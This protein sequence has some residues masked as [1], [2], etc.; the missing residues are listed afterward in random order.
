MQNGRRRDGSRRVRSRR[1][2]Q[3]PFDDQRE[4]DP[5]Q[6]KQEQHPVAPRSAV[7]A[8]TATDS[9]GADQVVPSASW[10]ACRPAEPRAARRTEDGYVGQA[11][12]VH[13]IPGF[14]RAGRG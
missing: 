2:G 4:A 1:F 13:L 6:G 9:L 5:G 10:R 14:L 11:F 12:P 7:L 8:A 3:L